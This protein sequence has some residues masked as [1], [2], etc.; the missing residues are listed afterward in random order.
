[1]SLQAALFSPASSGYGLF[2]G[3]PVETAGRRAVAIS[4]VQALEHGI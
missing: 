3:I 2:E 4:Q 1:M